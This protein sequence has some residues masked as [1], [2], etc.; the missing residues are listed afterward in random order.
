[1]SH[2]ENAFEYKKIKNNNKWERY[3]YIRKKTR[4]NLNKSETNK[5]KNSLFEIDKNTRK[6][7]NNNNNTNAIE[8]LH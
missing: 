2:F 3:E 6:K 8:T 4:E 7:Q 5:L 1:M